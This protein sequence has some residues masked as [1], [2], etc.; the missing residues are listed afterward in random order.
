MRHKRLTDSE[1]VEACSLYE[2]GEHTFASLA[3]RYGISPSAMKGLLNRR[4]Y[5]AKP[6]SE[7]TRKYTIDEEYFDT[8]RENQAY[9]LGFLYADGYHNTNRNTVVLSLAEKDREILERLSSEL[10]TDKPL[11]HIIHKSSYRRNTHQYR[12]SVC[13]KK[14]SDRL[15]KLGLTQCKT[16]T[17]TYP[18]WLNPKLH[19]HFIRG[20]VDGD[21]WVG[22]RGLSVVGTKDFCCSISA[23]LED[24][25]GVRCS[26]EIPHPEREKTTN[27]RTLRV[28]GRVQCRSIVQWLYTDADLFLRRKHDAA[29]ELL[30]TPEGDIRLI[31]KGRLCS[32]E[33]CKA[34]HHS[35]GYCRR[36]N[37]QLNGGKEKRRT[38]Y[39]EHAV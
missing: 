1:K 8:I 5:I 9:I 23:I 30:N 12:L 36:H 27:I 37:Y 22:E 11:Q 19:R 20:Y 15:L 6:T 13:S 21:G 31:M 7:L 29:M 34:K 16:F 28:S 2:A 25:L 38:R 39:V 17:L 32:V 14:I 35:N 18:Q 24:A 26:I 10:K 33:D 3:R 4:G